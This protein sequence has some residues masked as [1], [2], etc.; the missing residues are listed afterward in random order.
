MNKVYIV[1]L[2]LF[3]SGMVTNL[4]AQDAAMNAVAPAPMPE[5]VAPSDPTLA[6]FMALSTCT[7][8]NYTEKNTLS[9]E[10][11]QATLKQEIIGPSEDGLSCNVQLTTPDNRS[12]TCV[13]PNYSLPQVSDQRFLEGVLEA[14]AEDPQ[15]HSLDSDLVWSTLKS[16]YCS[17]E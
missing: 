16:S 3:V 13:F 10:V 12:M 11:G 8:G 4:H 17:F 15:Q 2:L 1:T 14:T 5:Q 7:P 9:T 6:F